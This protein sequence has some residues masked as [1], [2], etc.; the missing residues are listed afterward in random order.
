MNPN[1]DV[2]D[3]IRGLIIGRRPANERRRHFVTAYLIG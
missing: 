1:M 3:M 2:I